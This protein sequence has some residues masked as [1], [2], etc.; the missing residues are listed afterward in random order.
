MRHRATTMYV[1]PTFPIK[2]T[3]ADAYLVQGDGERKV[4]APK[5]LAVAL[6][7]TS[8]CNTTVLL[9]KPDFWAPCR[10]TVIPPV[11]GM[12][13]FYAAQYIKTDGKQEIRFFQSWAECTIS[14]CSSS[15]TPC[16]L[17]EYLYGFRRHK[18]RWSYCVIE[19]RQ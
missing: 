5:Q 2:K 19:H 11:P 12:S 9:V 16:L 4:S 3:Q 18:L 1:T 8:V 13:E 17:T 6:M 14:L 10:T 7:T 15:F